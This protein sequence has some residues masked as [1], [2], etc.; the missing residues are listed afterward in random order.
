[1]EWGF[2]NGKSEY[3]VSFGIAPRNGGLS[4]SDPQASEPLTLRSGPGTRSG[5][6]IRTARKNVGSVDHNLGGRGIYDEYRN[7]LPLKGRL[8][9]KKTTLKVFYHHIHQ[10]LAKD[11]IEVSFD[12]Q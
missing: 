11:V 4:P 9:K 3:E 5:L 6:Q 12:A 1:M 8:Q 7:P 2:G 10:K